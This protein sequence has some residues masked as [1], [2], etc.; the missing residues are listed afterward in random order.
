MEKNKNKNKGSYY[1]LIKTIII[2]LIDEESVYT[3]LLKINN[4]TLKILNILNVI[5]V[6]IQCI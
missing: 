5:G 2:N 6:A 3:N 1:I 4:I